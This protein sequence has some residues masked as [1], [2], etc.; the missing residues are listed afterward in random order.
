ML[1]SSTARIIRSATATVSRVN[2]KLAIATHLLPIPEA[3][4]Q[5]RTLHCHAMAE[6]TASGVRP[7][8]NERKSKEMISAPGYR[9]HE[10]G[11]TVDAL[12]FGGYENG[13]GLR[14]PE[15]A[16]RGRLVGYN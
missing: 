8:Q 2:L 5:I 14:E 11:C 4:H 12:L 13:V 15:Q 6:T 7:K 1:L 10:G 3:R 16:C 9:N